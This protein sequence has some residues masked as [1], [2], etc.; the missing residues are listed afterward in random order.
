MHTAKT[1]LAVQCRIEDAFEYV[2]DWHNIVNFLPLFLNLKPTSLVEYGPGSSLE[3]TLVV[4]RLQVSTELDTVEFQKNK[5]LVMKA[6]RGVRIR[7]VWEFKDVG[8][9]VLASFD[10][11]YEVPPALVLNQTER[12]SVEKDLDATVSKS[13]ELLKWILESMPPSED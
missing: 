9:K 13:M 3:A 8:G 5:R 1:R 7:L 6:S 4:G 12:E 10:F 2:A 11:D